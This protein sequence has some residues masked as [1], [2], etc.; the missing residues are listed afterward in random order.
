MSAGD[1]A[2]L[3]LAGGAGT[4]LWP[5]STDENPKQFLK[6]FDG[7]SLIQKTFQRLLQIAAPS[8]IFV[9][10]NDRYAIKVAEQLPELPADNILLEPARRN[11]APAIAICCA[12][13]EKRN[14]GVTIGIFPSDHA[15]Q[16]ETR[17]TDVIDR[18][19]SFAQSSEYL[20]TIGFEPTE[21]STGFGYLELGGELAAGIREVS[22]FVEKP[23]QTRAEQFLTAGNF[24]WNGGMFLWRAEVFRRELVSAAPE[25][26]RLTDLWIAET[27]D[28]KRAAIYEL[29]PSISIDFGVMEHARRVACV[30]AREVGWSDVGS[31]RAVARVAPR[32]GGDDVY[33]EGVRELYVS[34]TSGRPVAVVGFDRIA[35]VESE[36]GLLV[37]NLDKA[38]LLAKLV[39][40][41]R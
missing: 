15:I 20:V 36:D 11:T 33:S 17:F 38:E 28:K 31:W 25:I 30:T 2:V 24:D 29:M 6:I 40:T 1:R 7:Q 4:R 35:V 19:L 22:R 34:G 26:A 41:I 10:T 5:L 39:K 13:I 12:E 18:A 27:D 3:I 14:P 23:D 37:L 32:Q 21:P 9:S 8:R 16:Q